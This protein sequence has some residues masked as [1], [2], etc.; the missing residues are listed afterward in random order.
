M[1][2]LGLGLWL[3]QAVYAGTIT[4]TTGT[5]VEVDAPTRIITV[6]G[7]ITET[8]FA[9]GLGKQVA[10]VDAFHGAPGAMDGGSGVVVLPCGAG[11]TL[12]G[13]A[14]MVRLVTP[15]A[16]AARLGRGDVEW[17]GYDEYRGRVRDMLLQGRV[18][19]EGLAELEGHGETG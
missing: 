7:N 15:D 8:V 3:C 2:T 9:L 1:W 14:A 10:A 6:A 12:V 18:D 5:A 4:D 11:K 13:I 19:Y 16:L 17:G